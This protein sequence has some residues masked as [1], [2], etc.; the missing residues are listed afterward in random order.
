MPP[1]PVEVWQR[2]ADD[3]AFLAAAAEADPTQVAAVARLRKRYAAEELA[4]A[5]ELTR[6]HRK[7]LL[8]F[9]EAGEHWVADVPGVEQATSAAV[10]W[11]KAER[12]AAAGCQQIL[13]L[14][15]GVGGD[16]WG[17]AQRGLN[18]LAVDRDPVRA[19]MAGRNAGCASQIGDAAAWADGDEA[20]PPGTALHLDP[21]RRADGRRRYRL[22]DHEPDPATIRRLWERCPDSALKLSPA[23]DLTELAETFPGNLPG[24][25]ALPGA[26]AL[27]GAGEVEFISEA[28]RLVQAVLWTGRLAR[29]RKLRTAT[30]L[31]D[32]R[33][34]TLQGEPADDTALRSA[35]AGRYVFTVDPAAE[36]AGLLHQL[37][38]PALHPRLGLLTADDLIDDARSPWL[39]PFE[40]LADLPWH[41]DKPRAV[42]DWLAAHDG[43]IVEVK[44]RGKA[45]DPDRVQP[46][47]RGGGETPYTVFILRFDAS[48]RAL[49]TRRLP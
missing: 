18:V 28:G 10:A 37:A 9:P 20:I 48:I 29:P 4:V 27:P 17:F 44:T 8:K 46:Q 31:C 30:L 32:G 43:G 21:A 45:V 22:A 6:A 19:W 23:V 24:A 39:T 7:A 42:Q 41:H 15:C 49:I 3:E 12:F 33:T 35:P 40:L 34:H 14:G 16:A 47:L 1:H 26:E 2:V 11:H 36:R 5:F 38:L 13:D 25:A